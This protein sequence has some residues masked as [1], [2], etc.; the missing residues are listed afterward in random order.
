M[1]DVTFWLPPGERVYAVGDIHGLSASLD[2]LMARYGVADL[3]RRLT[4]VLGPDVVS[5]IEVRPPARR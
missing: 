2:A 5:R 3:L 4:G 1:T